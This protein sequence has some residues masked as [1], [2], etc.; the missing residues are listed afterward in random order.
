MLLLKTD[1]YLGLCKVEECFAMVLEY[2]SGGNLLQ[3][4]QSKG[5]KLPVSKL[6]MM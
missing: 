4:L 3:L 1:R 5:E 6:E 2:V